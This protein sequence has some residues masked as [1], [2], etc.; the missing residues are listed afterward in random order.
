VSAPDAW[1]VI[2]GAAKAPAG[3]QSAS[4][5][6]LVQKPYNQAP[7]TARFDDILVKRQ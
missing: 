2:K 1:Q 7:A 3:T 5:R 6:L 4:V